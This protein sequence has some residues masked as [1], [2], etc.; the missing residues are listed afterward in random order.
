MACL[1]PTPPPGPNPLEVPPW[2]P[3]W[4][5]L[6]PGVLLPGFWSQFVSGGRWWSGI[7]FCA[8]ELAAPTFSAMPCAAL[9]MPSCSCFR[10][11]ALDAVREPGGW[12]AA[13]VSPTCSYPLDMP[14]R[15]AIVARSAPREAERGRPA[16]DAAAA[17]T[18]RACACV[19]RS[20]EAA[21]SGFG[22]FASPAAC[23]SRGVKWVMGTTRSRGDARASNLA[24]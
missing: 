8:A 3:L 20:P 21:D 9:A 18:G 16:N 12:Y 11:S 7:F 22:T 24:L 5:A 15:D 17:T 1:G 14:K 2:K 6:A 4:N 19:S 23:T 13:G 10:S